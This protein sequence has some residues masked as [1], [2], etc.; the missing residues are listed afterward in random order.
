LTTWE[1]E[2][3]ACGYSFINPIFRFIEICPKCEAE[4]IKLAEAQGLTQIGLL[5]IYAL[6]NEEI[7]NERT[8][9]SILFSIAVHAK[10]IECYYKDFYLYVQE[11]FIKE[12]SKNQVIVE[13]KEKI[14]GVEEI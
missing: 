11:N 7:N 10:K 1:W 9:N 6:K 5:P 3:R 4:Y 13:L 2:C 8:K 12:I 14:S